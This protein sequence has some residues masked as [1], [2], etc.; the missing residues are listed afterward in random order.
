MLLHEETALLSRLG[1]YELR[2]FAMAPSDVICIIDFN[3]A[4]SAVDMVE[5]LR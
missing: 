4:A 3:R 1:Q 2:A 5:L